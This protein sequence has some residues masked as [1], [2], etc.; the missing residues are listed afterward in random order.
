MSR[1]SDFLDLINRLNPEQIAR[2][3]NDLSSRLSQVFEEVGLF[4]VLDT[5]GGAETRRRPDI[6]VYLDEGTA[7]LAGS[8]EIVVESK[9]P[10][11]VRG[12]LLSALMGELWENKFVAYSR[13]HIASIRYFVLT[14]FNRF[15]VVPINDDIRAALARGESDPAHFEPMIHAVAMSFDLPAQSA[16][17][18]EWWRT[19]FEPTA[20]VPAR[21]SSI[22]DVT[23]ISTRP[24]LDHFAE[25][26]ATIVAGHVDES[27][28]SAALAHSIR[29]VASREEELPSTVRASL[30]VYVMAQHRNMDSA[31]AR[32]VIQANLDDQ[33]NNFISASIHSLIGRLFAYKIIEDCFCLGSTDPLISSE[34]YV[35]HSNRYDAA[36]APNVVRLA[37][38]A[39]RALEEDTPPAIQDLSR[40]GSF[41]D[42]VEERVDARAFLRVFRLIASHEFSA[43]SGD[44]LGRF[45][46]YYAQRTN[47]RRRKELGQYYTPVEIVSFMWREALR[48]A[49][50]RTNREEFSVLDPGVGSATFLVEGAR[51]LSATGLTRFWDRLVG[52]DIDPQVIGVAYVNLFVAILGCMTRGE[53]GHLSSLRLYP[54]DALDPSNTAP[55]E[56]VLPLLTDETL[57]QFLQGQIDLSHEDKRESAYDI[58]IGNPPYHNNSNK[59]L[60]QVA[61]IFPRLLETSR[62]NA[63]AGVRNIRD[64]YAW[65]FAAA[66][67]YIRNEGLIAFVVSDSFC[68]L[69]SFRFFRIDLLRRYQVLRVVHLGP[70]VFDDVGPRISFVI[71]F[72][73][74]RQAVLGQPPADE[75]RYTDL[76]AM[77][78][79]ERLALLGQWGA[80]A[81]LAIPE[82]VHIPAQESGY[83]LTPVG[84]VAQAVRRAGPALS[85]R[86]G[87]RVFLKKWP[88]LITAFD[89]LFSAETAATLTTRWQ[90]FF[91]CVS[92]SRRF[93]EEL[94]D[95]AQS[96]GLASDDERSRLLDLVTMAR[97]ADLSFDASK[98]CRAISGSSPNGDRW[99]PSPELTTYV[100]YEPSLSI[101]RNQNEGKAVGWG[102]MNQWR[103][104]QA[105]EAS[106]K[107]VYTSGSKVEYGLK[108]FVLR[109]R[110]HVKLHGGTSQQ[111]NFT[112]ME[113]P[114]EQIKLGGQPNNLSPEAEPLFAEFA[115]RGL[116]PEDFMLFVAGLYNS[117]VAD[118]F[119]E[120]GGGNVLNIPMRDAST[121]SQISHLSRRM[122]DLTVLR[123][124]F[125]SSP[126]VLTDSLSYD[127][128]YLSDDAGFSVEQ[129]SG[130]RYRAQTALISSDA[131]GDAI[132]LQLDA[133]QAELDGLVRIIYGLA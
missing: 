90:S 6:S 74:R 101:P 34:R 49:G 100:Y 36:D 89:R 59:T 33:L 50:D 13:A 65:F 56:A 133:G 17:W 19:N 4:T 80:E 98:V 54:T 14:T 60:A 10:T 86:S 15:L 72:L 61:A 66:D 121:A 124:A 127:L 57:R 44:L 43:L 39:M 41:Y 16:N 12:P 24:E 58:V 40:A 116:G 55:L 107:L 47:K 62:A 29:I 131:T 95:F 94:A 81:A 113:N 126:R 8:A 73:E 119:V 84:D 71:V 106:P 76:R 92:A 69:P 109:D 52:F 129:E 7:D 35:F 38:A 77:D 53:A 118:L 122:R 87:Q 102:T 68:R 104:P 23:R 85:Q 105:Q 18:E 27:E 42:W 132:S 70:G 67:H 9:K 117:E 3:E 51:R 45:F 26:L 1:F 25:T 11:E 91:R 2:S 22:L 31:T 93:E 125:S 79:P 5:A 115:A 20:L 97:S 103:D 46:E 75:I 99:Y 114:L 37:F 83:A 96:I 78:V 112:V 63:R 111:F 108:A 30:M 48:A 128:V 130:G 110:W 123:H 82:T 64:D 88:G 32:A 21:H 120:D 28:S